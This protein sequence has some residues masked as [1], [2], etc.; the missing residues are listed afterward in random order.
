MLRVAHEQMVVFDADRPVRRKAEFEAGSDRA[1][2]AGFAGLSRTTR[3]RSPVTKLDVLVVGDGGAA[4]HVPEHVVPGV[5]DLAGEQAERVDLGL[6]G[7]GIAAAV[8]AD[9]RSLQISPI[10]LGFEAEHPVGRSASDSRS[11]RRPDRRWRRDSPRSRTAPP[12]ARDA[13]E[14]PA[15]AARAAAAVETDV[16]AA[17][18]VERARRSGAPWCRSAP[19]DR[20]RAQGQIPRRPV[21]RRPAKTF[22]SFISPISVHVFDFQAAGSRPVGSIIRSRESLTQPTAKYRDRRPHPRWKRVRNQG[23]RGPCAQQKG[24]R[25]AGLFNRMQL[26]AQISI[27]RPPGRPSGS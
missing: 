6:V 14:V 8:E 17:P 10:A 15:L 2:P 9:V 12:N 21:R 18:V 13:V 20:Q 4:L 5:A 27:S 16:E 7:I 26:G 25:E 23:R 22:S 11:D 3:R 19:R 1:A 24:R